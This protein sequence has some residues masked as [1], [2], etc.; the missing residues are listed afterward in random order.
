MKIER[1][2]VKSLERILPLIEGYQTFYKM[3]PNRARNQ[4]HFS[5]YV[6]DE[7]KGIMF[8]AFDDAGDPVGFATIYLVPSSASAGL[9]CVFNDLFTLPGER[10]SGVGVNL[11]FEIFRYAQARGYSSV[12]WETQRDNLT[13]QRLYD[14]S[15]AEK[16]EW[17]HYELKLGA[18]LPTPSK[19][20]Q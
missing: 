2:T 20:G 5:K 10:G 12:S 1:V 18:G 3:T 9:R 19:Q 8:A 14:L 17:F 7:N 11:A 13:A 4:E 15:G 16:T 6:D